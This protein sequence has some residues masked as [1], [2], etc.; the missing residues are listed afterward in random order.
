MQKH[1][2]YKIMNIIIAIYSV[3]DVPTYK[4]IKM[5]IIFNQILNYG[6]NKKKLNRII[7]IVKLDYVMRRS[8]SN[9][10]CAC[11]KY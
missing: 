9:C 2:N 1:V 5:K 3:T 6:T 10:V 4:S 7:S 11:F 8:N